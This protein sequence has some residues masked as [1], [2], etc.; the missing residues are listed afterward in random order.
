MPFTRI[1]NRVQ[2]YTECSISY[3][4]WY[5]RYYEASSSFW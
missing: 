1:L 4:H 3:K 5:S 2:S